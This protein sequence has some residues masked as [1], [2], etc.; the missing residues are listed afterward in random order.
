MQLFPGRYRRRGRRE[1]QEDGTIYDY[2]PDQEAEVPNYI[3]RY[4][5]NM[6]DYVD[7][8]DLYKK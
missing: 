8:F 4:P 1:D 6:Y 7:G 2:D 5:P 3:N